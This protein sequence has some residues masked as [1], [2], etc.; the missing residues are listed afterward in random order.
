MGRLD[1]RVAI[2]TGA[3]EDGRIAIGAAYAKALAAEGARAIPEHVRVEDLVGTLVYLASPDSD[4]MTGQCL[5]VDGG[6]VMM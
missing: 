6:D 1:G 3:S 4:A 5:I 2:V